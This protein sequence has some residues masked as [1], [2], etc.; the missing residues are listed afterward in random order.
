MADSSQVEYDSVKSHEAATKVGQG[1]KVVDSSSKGSQALSAVQQAVF[2]G[3]E[4]GWD[5]RQ[6]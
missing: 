5:P 1:K 6:W 4:G 2:W 3:N